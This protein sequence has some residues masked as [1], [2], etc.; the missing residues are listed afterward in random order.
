M[1]KISMMIILVILTS[2]KIKKGSI[3]W[4]GKGLLWKMVWIW[5]GKMER[6]A[7]GMRILGFIRFWGTWKITLCKS[8][9]R[10]FCM[11]ALKFR[12]YVLSTRL[13]RHIVSILTLP[14]MIWSSIRNKWISSKYGYVSIGWSN[15]YNSCQTNNGYSN[16]VPSPYLEYSLP[17]KEPQQSQSTTSRNPKPT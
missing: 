1:Y 10:L 14:W 6:K 5:M 13:S 8:L 4:W 3:L 11:L 15:Y 2:I 12:I 17:L 7:M 9:L 16:Q